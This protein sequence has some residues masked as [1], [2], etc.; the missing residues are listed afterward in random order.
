MIAAFGKIAGQR[1]VHRLDGAVVYGRADQHGRHR[2]HSRHRR[3]AVVFLQAQRIA[4]QDH[5][6][7]MDHQDADNGIAIHEGAH[8]GLQSVSDEGEFRSPRQRARLLAARNGSVGKQLV[9]N[10][11][12]IGLDPGR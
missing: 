10:A 5:A 11:V 8:V 3:P 1:F 7:A 6:P 12:R 9:D 4:F 2:F